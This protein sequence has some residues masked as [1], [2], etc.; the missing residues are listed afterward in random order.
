MTRRAKNVKR[1]RLGSGMLLT[2]C[3]TEQEGRIEL[4]E[5]K[6]EDSMSLNEVLNLPGMESAFDPYQAQFGGIA[7]QASGLF[8]SEVSQDTFIEVNEEG[9]EAAAV[10]VVTM[11]ESGAPSD[12][13]FFFAITDRTTGLIVF[14]IHGRGRE[15]GRVATK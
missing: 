15:S 11:E 5:F 12:R 6:L 1:L 3:L 14:R 10:T 4:P 2:A 13:P 8:V 9:T 7:K